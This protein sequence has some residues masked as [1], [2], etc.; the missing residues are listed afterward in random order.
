MERVINSHY[1]GLG[2]GF[3][4]INWVVIS[5]IQSTIDSMVKPWR[6]MLGGLWF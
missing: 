2:S 3:E 1:E 5:T 4:P 6:R